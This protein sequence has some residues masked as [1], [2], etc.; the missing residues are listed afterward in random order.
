V[1]PIAY[2]LLVRGFKGYWLDNDLRHLYKE[3]LKPY[4]RRISDEEGHS[5]VDYKDLKDELYGNVIDE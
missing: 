2:V 4:Y 3:I 1:P 5:C